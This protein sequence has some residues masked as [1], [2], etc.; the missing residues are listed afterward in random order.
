[1]AL[2]V[3]KKL[4]TVDEVLEMVDK[5]I[6][7]EDNHLELIRGELLVMSPSGS[8][9]GAAI[10]RIH[11]L[12]IEMLGRKVV[13]WDQLSVLLDPYSAPEPDIAVLKYRED[14]YKERLPGPGDILFLIEVSD[15]TL[16]T[17]RKIKGPLYAEFGI[18]EYWILNLEK[19]CVEQYQLPLPEGYQRKTII[20]KNQTLPL[21]ELG[22]E[23][24]VGALLGVSSDPPK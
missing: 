2:E 12:L 16:D 4:W 14:F 18:P 13:I 21:P 11:L 9:H 23:V 7:P 5:G 15:S 22:V 8:R 17:D 19:D 20:R 1:M 3:K 24:S 6:L 10:S